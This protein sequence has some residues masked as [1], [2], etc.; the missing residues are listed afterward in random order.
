MDKKNQNKN[1]RSD[2]PII[3]YDGSCNLCVESIQFVIQR[4]SCKQFRFA[5]LQSSF[6]DAYVEKPGKGNERLKSMVLVIGNQVYRQST[7]ALLTAKRLD[8]FWFF[9]TIFL[10]IPQPIRDFVYN[11]IAA[12][13]HNIFGKKDFCWTPTSDLSDRFIKP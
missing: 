9:L 12:H 2:T 7:A 1:I 10:L 3:L 5:S 4:D 13:R 11:W 8:G 6:A